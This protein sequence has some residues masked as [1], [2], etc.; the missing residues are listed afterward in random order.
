M[1]FHYFSFVFLGLFLG[2]EQFPV[3]KSCCS[4]CRMLSL[5]E[6]TLSSCEGPT[7]EP[8]CCWSPLSLAFTDHVGSSQ[9]NSA[10]QLL[11]SF[12]TA[13]TCCICAYHSQIICSQYYWPSISSDQVLILINGPCASP[14]VFDLVQ[15]HQ[16]SA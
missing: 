7:S 9:H 2:S 6:W 14:S 12:P 15:N 4:L 11:I 5:R 13:L 10:V 1:N 3:K 16:T 8:W